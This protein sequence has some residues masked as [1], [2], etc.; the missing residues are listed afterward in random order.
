MLLSLQEHS[1]AVVLLD[2]FFWHNISLDVLDGLC[3]FGMPLGI[4]QKSNSLFNILKNYPEINF[5]SS[6]F[7]SLPQKCYTFS[8]IKHLNIGENWEGDAVLRQW[9]HIKYV[10]AFFIVLFFFIYALCTMVCPLKMLKLYG[11]GVLINIVLVDEILC[12]HKYV[13]K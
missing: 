12:V 5:H 10:K 1:L 4:F 11:W 13:Y 9:N 6:D 2:N 8:L 3:W 7:I